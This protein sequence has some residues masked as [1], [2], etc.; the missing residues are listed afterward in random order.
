[1]AGAA[2]DACVVEQITRGREPSHPSPRGS[3]IH[4]ADVVQVEDDRHARRL[5]EAAISEADFR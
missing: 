1:V 2:G 3:S 5:A 4:G